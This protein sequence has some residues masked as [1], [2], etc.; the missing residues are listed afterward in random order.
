MEELLNFM[1]LTFFI[2]KRMGKSLGEEIIAAFEMRTTIVE[3]SH[4]DSLF[5]QETHADGH[6]V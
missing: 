4:Q 1:D 3:C 6:A 5:C 2:A